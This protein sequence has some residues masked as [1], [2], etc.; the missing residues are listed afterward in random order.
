LLGCRC[1]LQ[2][3][4]VPG[5]NGRIAFTNIGSNYNFDI[6]VMGPRRQR[7]PL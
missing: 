6:W 4:R 7:S 2:R 1:W 5:E 3:E